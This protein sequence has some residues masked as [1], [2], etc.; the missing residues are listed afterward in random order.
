MS[1]STVRFCM[2]VTSGTSQSIQ[3]IDTKRVHNLESGR[4][5]TLTATSTHKHI[6]HCRDVPAEDSTYR[7]QMKLL[8]ARFACTHT[9][10]RTD[11]PRQWPFHISSFYWSRRVGRDNKHGTGII[12]DDSKLRMLRGTVE[13]CVN[14]AHDLQSGRGLRNVVFAVW[15]VR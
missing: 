1:N 5:H 9:L 13:K 6:A 7:S 12:S 11:Q 14:E 3:H 2:S 10:K 15:L 8:A 4:T